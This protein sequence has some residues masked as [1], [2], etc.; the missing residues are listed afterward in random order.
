MSSLASYVQGREGRYVLATSRKGTGKVRSEPFVVKRSQ[1]RVRVGALGKGG[2]IRVR[3]QS[4]LFA[5]YR[6]PKSAQRIVQEIKLNLERCLGKSVFI[7]LI[8]EDDDGEVLVD[9]LR[10]SR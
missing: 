3:S 4:D 7:E 5:E 2:R 9:D 1:L 6:T 8:D 10:W